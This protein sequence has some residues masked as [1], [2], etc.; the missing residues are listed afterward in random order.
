MVA[1]LNPS[2]ISTSRALVI[3][4]PTTSGTGTRAGAVVAGPLAVGLTVGAA[5]REAG[6]EPAGRAGAEA[7]AVPGVDG[8]ADLAVVVAAVGAGGADVPPAAVPGDGGESW[9]RN[10][11]SDPATSSATTPAIAVTTRPGRRGRR[12][13]VATATGRVMAAVA[14]GGPA[15]APAGTC[16]VQ[17]GPGCR[18]KAWP[19]EG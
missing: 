18:G 12:P 19:G 7:V 2:P 9:K 10:A 4:M 11:M 13:A 17:P 8:A 3:V 1:T 16:S 6:G 5:A 15:A 14:G